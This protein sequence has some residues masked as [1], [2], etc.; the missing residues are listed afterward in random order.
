M[1]KELKELQA[2]EAQQL[3]EALSYVR[4]STQ[5]NKDK[6]GPARARGAVS[7]YASKAMHKVVGEVAE[8]ISGSLPIDRRGKFR[9]LMEEAG[10]RKI[11]TIMVENARAISRNMMV[12]EELYELSK[13]V[14][15]Q[16]VPAD[17]PD[18][19]KHDAGPMDK[20]LRR[21]VF[22]YQELEKDL[23]V[24]RLKDGLDKRRERLEVALR[25]QR[26]S[27]TPAGAVALTAA[28][29]VKVNGRQTLLERMRISGAVEA[30]GHG[31]GL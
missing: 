11:K 6:G 18:L 3:Q 29:K 26:R 14:G 9:D 10:E 1:A 22:A 28:G 4:T 2:K 25:Q 15:V 30:Q 5:T 12:S 17:F 19:M 13:K 7:A 21:I 16:I 23:V 27:R 24:H 8:V 31:Q 20:F